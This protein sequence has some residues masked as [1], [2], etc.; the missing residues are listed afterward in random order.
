MFFDSKVKC[1]KF[2]K[3][4]FVIPINNEEIEMVN[5]TKY[6]GVVLDAVYLFLVM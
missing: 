6:L 2:C 4:G 5:Q 3:S 1:R